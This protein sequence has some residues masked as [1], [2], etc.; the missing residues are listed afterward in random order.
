MTQSEDFEIDHFAC[1]L[2]FSADFR[3][4]N[5][6]LIHLLLEPHSLG[7]TSTA[8]LRIVFLLL[9]FDGWGL[10]IMGVSNKLL[11]FFP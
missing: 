5:K 7:G 11:Q 8:G 9:G 3:W 10:A 1:D 4:I 2:E 6:H